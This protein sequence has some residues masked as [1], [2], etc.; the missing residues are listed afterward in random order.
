MVGTAF[1]TAIEIIM[2]MAGQVEGGAKL[3]FFISNKF[4]FSR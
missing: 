2:G 4:G 3:F 1:F